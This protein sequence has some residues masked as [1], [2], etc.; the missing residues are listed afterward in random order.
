[1]TRLIEPTRAERTNRKRRARAGVLRVAGMACLLST[2][3]AAEPGSANRQVPSDPGAESA[4][5]TNLHLQIR[6][7]W[8]HQ[9]AAE[10]QF[11]IAFVTNNTEIARIRPVDFEASDRGERLVYDTRAG[12]GDVDG[13]TLNL[14]W[15]RPTQPLRKVQS[16]WQYLLDHG[17]AD[18]IARLKDDPGLQP[19][20]PLLTV[21]TDG[22]GT[23][24]FLDRPRTT[25]A[26]RRAVV[27]GP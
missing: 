2:W 17:T 22:D 8:G 18:Q 20:A 14:S 26:A 12:G 16:I 19:D 9:S 27:A 24:G 6:L 25:G 15:T 13:V 3:A 7:S 11:A 4:T 1:M 5:P 10:R 21:L 23:R